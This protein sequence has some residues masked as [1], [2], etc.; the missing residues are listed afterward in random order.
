MV[1]KQFLIVDDDERFAFLVAK[2]L[3]EHAKC[4]TALSGD[5][6]LL[7]FEHHLREKSPFSAVFMDIYMPDMDGHTVVKRI[8][9]AEGKYQV[10]PTEAVKL[11]MLSGRK[12]IENVSK[13]FFHGN[14][15]AYI[16]KEEFNEKLMGELRKIS[17]I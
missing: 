12:D 14:A 1:P 2:K 10:V 5:D 8:R 6:A 9:E 7:Q 17:L 3:E 11:I 16:H 4:F 13:A 15:D